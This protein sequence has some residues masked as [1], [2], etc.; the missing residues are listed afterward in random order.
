MSNKNWLTKETSEVKKTPKIASK[1]FNFK[2]GK[3]YLGRNVIINKTL[4]SE[5]KEIMNKRNIYIK[6]CQSFVKK[7]QQQKM[8]KRIKN[9]RK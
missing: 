1:P 3:N 5:V 4:K 6:R 7:S 2:M 8:N 9:G